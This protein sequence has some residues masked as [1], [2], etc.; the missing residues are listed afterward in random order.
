MKHLVSALESLEPM[1]CLQM[2]RNKKLDL[3]H[4]M[5]LLEIYFFDIAL[6]QILVIN[7][8]RDKRVDLLDLNQ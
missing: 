1:S 3:A 2:Y 8:N 7:P 6:N 5:S 4:T